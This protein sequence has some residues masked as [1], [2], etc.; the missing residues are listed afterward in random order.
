MK[1]QAWQQCLASPCPSSKCSPQTLHVHL[2]CRSCLLHAQHAWAYIA[3]MLTYNCQ[4]VRYEVGSHAHWN[5]HSWTVNIWLHLHMI[6]SKQM[7]SKYLFFLLG[8]T[9]HWKSKS[10]SS[11]VNVMFY[12]FI[13]MCVLFLRHT[14]NC[15]FFFFICTMLEFYI[16]AIMKLRK[17]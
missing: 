12:M 5:K 10:F 11:N 8:C 3:A 14:I 7:H 4:Y 1:P 17:F 16:T 15:D 6:T 9:L 2:P 13:W